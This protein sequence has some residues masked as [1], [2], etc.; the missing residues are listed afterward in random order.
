MKDMKKPDSENLRKLQAAESHRKILMAA[1]KCFAEKGYV[2]ASVRDIVKVVGCSVNGIS[3]HFGSKEGLAEAVV[4]ELQKTIVQ[5]IAHEAE[6]I[7]SDFAWRVAVKRFV[8]DVIALFTAKEEPN[9]YFAA[10]YRHEHA[11]LSAKKVTLHEEIILP[12]FHQLEQLMSL[13]VAERDPLTTRL[14]TLALWNNVL[15]Y[16]L[17]HPVVLAEDIPAGMSPDLFRATTID[18]MVDKCIRELKFTSES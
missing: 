10:L 7:L 17:K 9:C 15:I 13:G 8:A 1:M 4:R 5:P 18:F 12:I 16:A 11:N 14:W 3:A 2:G 6:Q